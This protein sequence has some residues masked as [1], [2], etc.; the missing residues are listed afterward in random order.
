[1]GTCQ[2]YSIKWRG[3]KA[4]NRAKSRTSPKYSTNRTHEGLGESPKYS[5][6][7][8]GKKV[9]KNGK[10]GHFCAHSR[11]YG[12]KIRERAQI[13]RPNFGWLSWAILDQ[14]FPLSQQFSTKFFH[15]PDFYHPPPP[16]P[17]NTIL[18]IK[19]LSKPTQHIWFC[20]LRSKFLPANRFDEEMLCKLILF[21]FG[22]FISP[23]HSHMSPA[24]EQHTWFCF[25]FFSFHFTF[26][27]FWW[28]TSRCPQQCP[29]TLP[30]T[31]C[32][33]CP[34]PPTNGYKIHF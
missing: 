22:I 26:V 24:H 5:R 23:Q 27:F 10:N 16:T 3:K 18:L 2:K 19:L 11:K 9:Q 25:L 21:G 34:T 30:P 31:T 33:T 13:I 8:R 6:S 15:N 12:I 20:P 4:Q 29:R 7:A 32:N 28:A 17:P 1:M 14:I